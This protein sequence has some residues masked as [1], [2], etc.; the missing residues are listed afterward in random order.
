MTVRDAAAPVG[1]EA[2]DEAAVRA[3]FLADLAAA[4]IN[5]P[6]GRA[7]AAASDFLTLHRQARLVRAACAAQA[8][9]PLGFAPA[10]T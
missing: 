4:G 1:E 10:G 9:L 8:P 6:P 2:L 5:L 7:E 3:R